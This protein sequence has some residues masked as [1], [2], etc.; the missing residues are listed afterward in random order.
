VFNVIWT[1]YEW[2]SLSRW[3]RYGSV[4]RIWSDLT[5]GTSDEKRE[6]MGYDSLQ[7]FIFFSLL[8]I[9]TWIHQGSE[10]SSL[11]D[12]GGRCAIMCE[13][14]VEGKVFLKGYRR[15][16]LS[17]LD[18][19]LIVIDGVSYWV[20]Y[21]SGKHWGI[22]PNVFH[23]VVLGVCIVR[24]WDEIRKGFF[25]LLFFSSFK[26]SFPIFGKWRV[27]GSELLRVFFFNWNFLSRFWR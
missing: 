8:C 25:L 1:G 2:R 11:S 16:I 9:D 24:I 22:I 7:V 17:I 18:Q 6:C 4:D 20:L 27:K 3:I 13:R 19:D 14:S 26:G 12:L 5:S 21:F 15:S 23:S 10:G